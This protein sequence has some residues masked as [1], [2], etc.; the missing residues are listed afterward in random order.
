MIANSLRL[1][2]KAS[3]FPTGN[4]PE[5]YSAR[6]ICNRHF[7]PVQFLFHQ[8]ESIIS[9]LVIGTHGKNGLAPRLQYGTAHFSGGDLPRDCSVRVAGSEAHVEFLAHGIRNR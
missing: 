5:H 2:T 9:N 6:L 4:P 3:A 1:A 8:V 7:E